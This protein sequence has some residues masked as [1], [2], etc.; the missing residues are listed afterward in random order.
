MAGSSSVSLTAHVPPS[1]VGDKDFLIRVVYK[2]SNLD[3]VQPSCP[4]GDAEQK[5]HQNLLPFLCQAKAL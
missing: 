5:L 1:N 4:K 3:I 2:L